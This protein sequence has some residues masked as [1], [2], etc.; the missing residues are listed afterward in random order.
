MSYLPTEITLS[1]ATTNKFSLIKQRTGITPNL[2]GRVA[3]MKALESNVMLADLKPVEATGQKIPKD[4]FFGEDSDIYDLS[5]ELYSKSVGFEG[6][7][8]DLVNML[9]DYGA[10]TIPSIKKISDLDCLI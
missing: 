3:I 10:H 2:M 4:I 8:K 7:P 6:L 9:V 1:R 5:L